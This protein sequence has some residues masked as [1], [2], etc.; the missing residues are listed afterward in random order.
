MTTISVIGPFIHN[1][2]CLCQR[3]VLVPNMQLVLNLLAQ[4]RLLLIA[5]RVRIMRILRRR[6]RR[7][8]ICTR[9]SSILLDTLFLQQTCNHVSLAQLSL[10]FIQR[11]V[12]FTTGARLR[13]IEVSA[14]G[15]ETTRLDVLLASALGR[16]AVLLAAR[17]ADDGGAAFFLG[18]GDFLLAAVV[19]VHGL[20]GVVVRVA[21]LHDLFGVVRLAADGSHLVV[22]GCICGLIGTLLFG[23]WCGARLRCG[24]GV[25]RALRG[26]DDVGLGWIASVGCHSSLVGAHVGVYITARG[27][28]VGVDGYVGGG[29]G[30][31]GRGRFVVRIRRGRVLVG[32]IGGGILV[33]SGECI[34][35]LESLRGILRFSVG[36]ARVFRVRECICILSSGSIICITSPRIRDYP[37]AVTCEGS[38]IDTL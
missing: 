16:L 12:S 6:R 11:T 21:L 26:I 25:G 9:G 2:L 13:G 15:S 31:H 19:H 32:G 29:L 35:L 14:V 34:G 22:R 23:E 5:T 1:C 4:L 30:V 18:V 27:G 7:G 8:S 17:V 10:H 33:Y 38:R 24:S 20:A 3:L 36:S 28:I 37:F